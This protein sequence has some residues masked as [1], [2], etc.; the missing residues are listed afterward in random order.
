M[1]CFLF[2]G[3]DSNLTHYDSCQKKNLYPIIKFLFTLISC[4][5]AYVVFAAART[6]TSG[7]WG[8]FSAL[9][10]NIK[11]PPGSVVQLIYIIIGVLC[12]GKSVS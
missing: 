5:F 10:I 8:I 6:T 9:S 3:G 7:T 2:F 1:Y 12:Y 11:G 4:L